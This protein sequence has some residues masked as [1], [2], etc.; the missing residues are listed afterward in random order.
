MR[1]LEPADPTRIGPYAL[2]GRLGAGGM[3]VVYLGRS[4]G[5]RTVA[6]KVVRPELAADPGFRAR[7]RAEVNAARAASSAFTAPVVDADTDA[8]VP[9]MATAF[10]PG[11]ALDEAVRLVGAFPEHVLRI[12]AAGIAEELRNIH[13]AGLIHRDLKPS[14]VLLALD[15]PH[16]I[17]FG[18]ARAADGTALTAEGTVLGSAAFMSPEQASG[19]RAGPPSDVFS[20]GSTL[21]YAGTGGTAPFG[22]G[23]PLHVLYQVVHE[24]PDLA[25]VPAGVRLLVAA[26]LAKAPGDRPTPQQLA[27]SQG[28]GPLTPGTWLHPALVAAIEEAAAVMAPSSAAAALPPSGLPPLPPLPPGQPAAGPDSPPTARQT[29]RLGP[30]DVRPR[31]GRR[32]L[33][34]GLAGGVVVAAAGGGTVFL[35]GGGAPEK[36][37]TPGA[38]GPP[39]TAPAADPTDSSRS[40]DTDV[41]ATPLW[42]VPLVEPVIAL[43]GSGDTVVAAGMT[44]VWAVDR[45]GQ[46]RWGPLTNYT[47]PSGAGLGDRPV[48]VDATMAYLMGY[49]GPGNLTYALKAVDLATGAAAWTLSPPDLHVSPS[50]SVVGLLDGLVYVAGEAKGTFHLADPT[51]PVTYAAAFVWAVE[52]ATGRLRWQLVRPHDVLENSRLSVPSAGT[53][54]L[55]ETYAMDLTTYRRTGKLEALDT[56]NGGKSLWEQLAPGSGALVP[57]LPYFADGPHTSA[58]GYFLHLAD[59]L[60]AVDPADGKVVWQSAGEC[61]FRSAVASPDG[62]TVFA[63]GS[64]YA[65]GVVVVQS[66]DA[67]TGAVHWSGSLASAPLLDMAAHYADGTVYIWVHGK[68]WALDPATGAPRWTFGFHPNGGSTTPVPYWA[69]G[70][71]IYGPTDKGLAAIAADGKAAH[72]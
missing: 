39:A 3:G 51:A 17:D 14:N 52:P 68:V 57:G 9:W 34:L 12:L 24:E 32:K 41:V 55:F 69:G 15:G 47:S 28:A 21:A 44:G 63:V 60:Y 36:P 50:A 10:V 66:F 13:A 30:V 23:H 18:I 56:G 58:G 71:R 4:A 64:H 27:A 8:P 65:K 25:A 35:T 62:T 67:R 31:P 70:G 43:T 61:N 54:L 46:T 1:R 11:I 53:R 45:A 6:V 5:G 22:G 19:E 72:G 20:L 33:L 49:G 42:T 16:V 7:F 37:K 26:C 48:A 29:V 38:G 2:L 59:R 40:L